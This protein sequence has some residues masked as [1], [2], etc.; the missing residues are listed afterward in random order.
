MLTTLCVFSGD[1]P[2]IDGRSMLRWTP[3][4]KVFL[5]DQ[6][7]ELTALKVLGDLMFRME[8]PDGACLNALVTFERISMFTSLPCCRAS[9]LTPVLCLHRPAADDPG[10]PHR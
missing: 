8:H 1:V 6:Q 2:H 4:L 10:C 3:L 9:V 5:Q 7:K